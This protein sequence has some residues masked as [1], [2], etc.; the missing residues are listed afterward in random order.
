MKSDPPIA[1]RRSPRHQTGQGS[2]RPRIR[3]E[4]QP[5]ASDPVGQSDSR[6]RKLVLSDD[7]ADDTTRRP[8]DR[9]TTKK[10]PKQATPR[11]KTSSRPVPKIRKSSR[12]NSYNDLSCI[13]AHPLRQ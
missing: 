5:S 4:T 6:K 10:L 8:V 9:E 1:Q 11:K 3:Y 12:C 2:G 7:E 13:D